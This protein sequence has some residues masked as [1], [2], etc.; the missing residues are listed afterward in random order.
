[1]QTRSFKKLDDDSS[2]KPHNTHLIVETNSSGIL[3]LVDSVDQTKLYK[4]TDKGKNWSLITTRD[5]NIRVLWHD[6]TNEKLYL[7]D[8]NNNADNNDIDV[9]YIDLTDDSI[10]SLGTLNEGAGEKLYAMDIFIIVGQVYLFVIVDGVLGQSRVYSVDAPGFTEIDATANNPP[11]GIS[12]SAIISGVAY[13]VYDYVGDN[14]VIIKFDNPNLSNL[15]NEGNFQGGAVDNLRGL[16]SDNSDILYFIL[17]DTDDNKNY[18][19]TYV[20]TSDTFTQLAEYNVALML[21]RNN[22]GIA[23]NEFEKGFGISDQKVYEIK[24]RRGGVRVLQNLS[25]QLGVKQIKWITDNF[26]YAE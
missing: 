8:C 9:A 16:A 25:A 10:N 20:I 12:Y 13:W 26:L 3:Y 7:C 1:M 15:H 24:P 14:I 6:R 23:P 19:C 21:D 22:S 5:E 18:L 17:E 2:K 4:T 11:L